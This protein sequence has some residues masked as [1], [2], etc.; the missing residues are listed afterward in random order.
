LTGGVFHFSSLTLKND[1][2]LECAAPCE[3]RVQGRVSVGHRSSIGP[4]AA[5]PPGA[6][7]LGAGNV[8]VA[9]R[10]TNGSSGPSGLP[11]AVRID[12]ESTLEAYLLATNGTLSLAH[13]A[14]LR[15]K[16]VVK[17]A[18]IGIDGG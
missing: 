17:D 14:V 15:G 6:G 4:A 1:A 18:L 16:A 5:G 7:Q 8:V 9:V 13:R 3:L 11:A 12:N 2:R 10:G